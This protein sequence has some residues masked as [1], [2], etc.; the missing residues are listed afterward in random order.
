MEVTTQ[1]I[2]WYYTLSYLVPR[3]VCA[4]TS[5]ALDEPAFPVI[6]PPSIRNQ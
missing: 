5:F 3:A 2:V 4:N 6:F 1:R